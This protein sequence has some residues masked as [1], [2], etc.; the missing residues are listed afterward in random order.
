MQL[1]HQLQTS[2]RGELSI[3]DYVEKMMSIA[4]N[5]SL[6]GK[7]ADE[8]YLVTL[9][10]NGLWSKYDG[11]VDSIQARENPITLADLR[12]LLLSAELRHEDNVNDSITPLDG[13]VTALYTSK[14]GSF[15]YSS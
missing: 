14:T 7:P 8:D 1:K 6:V 12:G 11:T 3:L 5:L 2:R 13:T 10:L 15:F 4:D 9:I